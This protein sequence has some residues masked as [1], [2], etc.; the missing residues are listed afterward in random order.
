MSDLRGRVD[1]KG[2]LEG[3]PGIDVS[4]VRFGNIGT[5]QEDVDRPGQQVI[6]AG[7]LHRALFE[8]VST[9]APYIIARLLTWR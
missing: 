5:I 2:T 9:G 4:D 1:T 6:I 8:K 7:V 3:I